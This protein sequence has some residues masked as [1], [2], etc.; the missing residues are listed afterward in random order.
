MPK[1]RMNTIRATIESVHSLI[2]RTEQM[3]KMIPY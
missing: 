1:N 3:R 2:V